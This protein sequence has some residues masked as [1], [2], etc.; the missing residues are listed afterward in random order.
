MN[1]FAILAEAYWRPDRTLVDIALLLAGAPCGPPL[2][3]KAE[4]VA[5]ERLS[6]CAPVFG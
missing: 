1:E 2:N 6:L 4:G 5:V 3:G